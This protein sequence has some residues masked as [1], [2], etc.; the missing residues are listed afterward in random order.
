MDIFQASSIWIYIFIFFGK[1]I[2]VAVSTIRL[3]LIN[4]GER[5]KGSIIAVFEMLLWL[6]ITGT[7]LIGC[8]D[9]IFRLFVFAIAFAVGN[10]VG[11]WMEDKLAFGLCSLQLIVPESEKSQELMVKLRANNFAVT[12]VKGKGKDGNRDVMFLHI[13]RKRISRAVELIKEDME[14][15][16]IVIN[17]SKIV[18]GGFIS[19]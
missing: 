12:T 9:D 7:V 18:H 11:S 17:D 3:V 4:R 1:I 14:N 19:K 8:S 5:L 10:Y 16:V 2:E 6:F 15:A 13:K